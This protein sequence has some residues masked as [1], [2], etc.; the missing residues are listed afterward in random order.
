[1]M[2]TLGSPERLFY[3]FCLEDHVPGDHPLRQIDRFL[4]LGSV[5]QELAR[6]YSGIGRP[7]ID[8]DAGCWLLLC[9]SV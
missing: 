7:S 8:P 1:M 2:G 5:R 9:H 4:E 3:D 6:H